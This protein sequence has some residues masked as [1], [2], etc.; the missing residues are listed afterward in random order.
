MAY[1]TSAEVTS[2]LTG[3]EN[4]TPL[5]MWTV[6]V[7][8][9]LEIFGGPEARSGTGV[10]GLSGLYWYSERSTLLVHS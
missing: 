4:F 1:L 9:P 7:L 8:S 3:G 10:I 6:I 5:R 2:R